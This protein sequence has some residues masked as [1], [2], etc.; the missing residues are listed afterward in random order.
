MRSAF[1]FQF[2]DQRQSLGFY[3]ADLVFEA[4]DHS[5]VRKRHNAIQHGRALALQFG[6]L[7][8]D[9]GLRRLCPFVV[10]VPGLLQNLANKFEGSLRWLHVFQKRF[11]AAFDISA[12]DRL[13]VMLASL[14]EAHVVRMACA[15]LGARPVGRQRLAACAEHEGAQREVFREIGA[16]WH[17]GLARQTRL[18][19]VEGFQRDETFMFSFAKV[20][21]VFRHLQMAGIQQ[22]PQHSICRFVG[23]HAE[24]V[25]R[26]L[27][28]A[29]QKARDFRL[30]LKA[31]RGVRF[32]SFLNN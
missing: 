10:V 7:L 11:E 2:L 6:N 31:S 26:E 1:G 14:V 15:R 17:I 13:A 5:R 19:P 24:T 16:R 18:Y 29:L 30:R 28:T 27:R 23:D 21:A 20:D 4:G 25:F 22:A 32:Q 12:P 3:R 8:P 9:G